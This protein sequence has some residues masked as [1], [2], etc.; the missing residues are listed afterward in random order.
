M[1][2]AEVLEELADDDDGVVVVADD[3][4]VSYAVADI[5][6]AVADGPG[7]AEF[8]LGQAIAAAAQRTPD[9]SSS[10]RGQE[11]VRFAPA[12]LDDHAID[13]AVAW[14]GSAARRARGD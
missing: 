11:W 3:P 2:L 14:F 5:V 6:F 13:R 9:T 7:A 10:A 4:V 8:R 1:T 12:D